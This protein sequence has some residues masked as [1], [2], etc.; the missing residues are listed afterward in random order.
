MGEPELVSVRATGPGII[1]INGRAGQVVK[2]MTFDVDPGTA[3]QYDFL[4]VIEPTKAAEPEDVVEEK[5]ETKAAAKRSKSGS[6]RK[7]K[8]TRKAAS[9]DEAP[10]D[11]VGEDPIP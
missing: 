1:M 2:D 7:R 8:T 9:K 3:A 10:A 4:E 6:T 11:P 5:K